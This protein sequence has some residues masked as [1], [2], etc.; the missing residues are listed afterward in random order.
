MYMAEL[1]TP[2]NSYAATFLDQIQEITTVIKVMYSHQLDQTIDLLFQVWQESRWVY[3]LGNGGSASTAAHL[4]G[5]LAKTINDEPGQR[6]IKAMTP[7]D[8]M[9]Q[10][11]A[12]VNDRPKEDYFTAWLDTFYELGGVGIGISVHGGSGTD[13]GG[14]WSQNL[15]KG[16][17]YIKDHGGQ[18]IGLSGFE[19]GPM[20]KNL[21]DIGIVVPA[22]STA[23]VEGMHV[24]LHHLIIFGLKER[25]HEYK[26][27]SNLY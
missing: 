9:T 23:I 7:W 22:P 18:T 10:S 4:A 8:N 13:F 19:G 27:A 1:L 6:G 15:L 17:Q 11:T 12:I 20:I 3:V 26:K 21:V 2:A 16:L 24:V 5:D 14:K 25:I